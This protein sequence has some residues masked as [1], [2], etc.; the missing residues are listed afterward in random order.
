MSTEL[1]DGDVLRA[2]GD[3]S[4]RGYALSQRIEQH[5]EE[6]GHRRSIAFSM[7]YRYL[8]GMVDRRLLVRC[9][10]EYRWAGEVTA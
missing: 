6:V 3:E 4:L 5:W 1:T 10:L 9:G 2:L 8:D 7:L